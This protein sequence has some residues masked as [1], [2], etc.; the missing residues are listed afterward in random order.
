MCWWDVHFTPTKTQP[1]VALPTR[2]AEYQSL[3]N[4]TCEA[5]WL[6]K[7]L[8]DLQVIMLH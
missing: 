3:A 1:T 8:G 5:T 7:L 2:E 4:A 6:K